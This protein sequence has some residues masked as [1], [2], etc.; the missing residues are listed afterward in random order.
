[1]INMTIKQKFQ[2]ILQSIIIRWS[3]IPAY[4]FIS[5]FPFMFGSE[6]KLFTRSVSTYV[7][8]VIII[9]FIHFFIHIIGLLGILVKKVYLVDGSIDKSYNDYLHIYRD[10]N[11]RSDL[12]LRMYN[13]KYISLFSDKVKSVH[14]HARRF[15]RIKI[16]SLDE[17]YVSPWIYVTKRV[18]KNKDKYDYKVIVYKNEAVTGY[19]QKK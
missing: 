9:I 7:I 12:S 16:K 14:V 10:G 11:G 5:M 2:L 6:F 13:K 1:M 8:I 18:F 19:Y 15:I 3:L 4:L 17:R